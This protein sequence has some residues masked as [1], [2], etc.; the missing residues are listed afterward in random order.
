MNN[1][2]ILEELRE[3]KIILATQQVNNLEELSLH[4]TSRL[5]H[6]RAETIKSLVKA[7]EIQALV[8]FDED[9]KEIY[10]FTPAHIKEYQENRIYE[11][12]SMGERLVRRRSA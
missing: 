7:G 3:I 8:D 4:K 2:R 1:D 9:G 11:P 5:L 12:V 10:K 6:K